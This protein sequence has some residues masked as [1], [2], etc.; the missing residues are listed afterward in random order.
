[1]SV[2]EGLNLIGLELPA[3]AV[4]VLGRFAGLLLDR[5]VP[6]GM[7]GRDDAERLVPRHVIDSLRATRLVAARGGPDVVDVGS[8]A[9]L[10]GIPLAIALPEVRFVLAEPWA[11]RTAFLELAV[12]QLGLGNVSVHPSRAES[13]KGGRFTGATARA[14]APLD[15][16][17]SVVHPL[18]RPGGILVAF[19][20][21]RERPPP[22]LAGAVEIEVVRDRLDP[23][24]PRSSRASLLATVGSLVIITS[25]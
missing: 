9:G 25:K 5:A 11:N 13:L 16:T 6:L 3:S 4:A 17:W 14:F 8:G 18:L 20:G 10:P 15:S 24:E 7:I 19:A 12:A 21:A 2:E 23:A 1:M 22:D